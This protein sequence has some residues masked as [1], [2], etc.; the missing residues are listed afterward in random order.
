VQGA[1]SF[2]QETIEL[3]VIDG[4]S[5]NIAIPCNLGVQGIAPFWIINGSIYELL[6]IHTF[7]PGVTIKSFSLLTIAV[8][9]RDLDGVTFQCGVAFGDTV[10]YGSIIRITVISSE[11]THTV[12][13]VNIIY[14]H[15]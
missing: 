3:T 7:L 12:K 1:V 2:G 15:Y 6:N 11:Y 8:G 14:V 4:V 5:T 9:T 10:L 13:F